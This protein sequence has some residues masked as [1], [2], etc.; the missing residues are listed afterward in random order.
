MKFYD[1]FLYL[2][3][4]Y[5]VTLLDMQLNEE[6]ILEIL[7]S[8]FQNVETINSANIK[9]NLYNLFVDPK[10]DK[11]NAILLD[12]DQSAF[13][14]IYIGL[15]KMIVIARKDLKIIICNNIHKLKKYFHN[16]GILEY[17]E[18]KASVYY[19]E[20]PIISLNTTLVNCIVDIFNNTSRGNILVFVPGVSDIQACSNKLKPHNLSTSI[21]KSKHPPSLDSSRRSVIFSTGYG[22]EAE[23]VVDSGLEK[24]AYYNGVYD[25]L[26]LERTSKQ[27]ADLRVEWA[28]ESVY[29][30]YTES[31]YSGFIEYP[32]PQ[33]MFYD[34]SQSLY[35]LFA[36]GVRN[37]IFFNFISKPS[38]SILNSGLITLQ[39]ANILNNRGLL[40]SLGSLYK[41]LPI[42]PRYIPVIEYAKTHNCLIH[43]L[44]IISICHCQELYSKSNNNQLELLF[45]KFNAKEGDLFLYHR[46]YSEYIKNP[47]KSFADKNHLNYIELAKA[48]NLFNLLK[49]VLVS[50]CGIEVSTSVFQEEFVK[51]AFLQGFF[52]NVIKFDNNRYY[53]LDDTEVFIHPTSA[54]YNEMPKWFIYIEGVQTTKLFVRHLLKIDWNWI[55]A[56]SPNSF[57]FKSS[58]RKFESEEYEDI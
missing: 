2:L 51:K 36:L 55:T 9:K 52:R 45:K 15:L 24:N 12:Y 3:S 48:H 20:N 18:S 11:Y 35:I 41:E 57:E 32:I 17:R 22:M 30:L 1:E 50:L 10:L 4:S 23:F 42:D 38:T 46:I 34:S 26:V 29:R 53:R 56:A 27:K 28:T 54:F 43:V 31:D 25:K 21:L 47:S 5:Q 39:E 58:K 16:P 40:T 19:L 37:P 6:E 14:D 33:I 49:S 44:Q 8:K 13:M 7:K